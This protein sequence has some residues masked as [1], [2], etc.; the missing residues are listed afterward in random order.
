MTFN[1]TCQKK[2]KISNY[3]NLTWKY[4]Y[5]GGGN[6]VISVIFL[7]QLIFSI[8]LLSIHQNKYCLLLPYEV[9]SP[10]NKS[11]EILK[12]LLKC[13]KTTKAISLLFYKYRNNI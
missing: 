6:V 7:M 11:T 13:N 12:F 10:F 9:I 5:M 4:I 8:L 1:T 2:G 3:V